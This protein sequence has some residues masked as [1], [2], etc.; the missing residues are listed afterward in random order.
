MQIM[1]ISTISSLLSLC[2]GSVCLPTQLSTSS[3]TDEMQPFP[4]GYMHMNFEDAQAVLDTYTN[5]ILYEWGTL[6][7]DEH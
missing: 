4:H 5:T 2:T 1:Y 7:P 3:D 6:N